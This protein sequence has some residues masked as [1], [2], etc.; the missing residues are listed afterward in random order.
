[1]VVLKN[2]KKLPKTKKIKKKN[3]KKPVIFLTKK[4]QEINQLN[5]KKSVIVINTIILLFVTLFIYLK[6][7]CTFIVYKKQN[8]FE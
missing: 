8:Y 6:L 1:V 2:L 4:L 7:I 5:K 3:N